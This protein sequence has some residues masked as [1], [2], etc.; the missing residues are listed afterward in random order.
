MKKIGEVIFQ[1]TI[2]NLM[3]SYYL[4]NGNNV[5]ELEE[6]ET[7]EPFLTASVNMTRSLADDEVYIK[8]YSENEGIKSIL[9][10][11]GFIGE[12]IKTVQTGITIHKLLK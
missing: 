5:L 6:K 3:K 2:C 8:D 11:D 4:S 1:G 9:T 12:E 10:M 7:G